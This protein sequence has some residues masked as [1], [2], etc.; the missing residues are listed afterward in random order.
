MKIPCDRFGAGRPVAAAAPASAANMCIDIR[1]IVS[2]QSKD[3][4]TMV[5]KMKDGTHPGEPSAGLLPGPEITGFAWQLPSGDTKVCETR[6]AFRVL[7]SGAD[8]HPGQVRRARHGK[9]RRRLGIRWR[10]R[11]EVRSVT[12]QSPLFCCAA[13]LAWLALANLWAQAQSLPTEK[14]IVNADPVTPGK[15]LHVRLS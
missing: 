3:G 1:D 4:R 12:S 11:G 5:F 2:S 14:V 7:Q 13:A 9:A 15:A 10:Q 6:R 8:L